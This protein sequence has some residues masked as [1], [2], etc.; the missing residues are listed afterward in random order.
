M[1]DRLC[2]CCMKDLA[3]HEVTAQSMPGA[4][5][6]IIACPEAPED[7][8]RVVPPVLTAS[9]AKA[10]RTEPEWAKSDTH[11]FYGPGVLA[12]RGRMRR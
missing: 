12:P 2:P 9:M 10:Q 7:G 5:I 11:W 8:F 1:A 3:T 6:E 4:D